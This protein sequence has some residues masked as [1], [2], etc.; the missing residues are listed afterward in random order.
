[1]AAEQADTIVG[2]QVELKGSLKNHG[3]IH[4]HGFVTGDIHSDAAVIIGETAVVTGPVSA[5]V[6]EVGG[7]VHGSITAEEHIELHPKSLVKGDLTTKRLS[8]KAG[9]TFIGKSSM[10]TPHGDNDEIEKKKPRLE[11]E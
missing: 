10:P 3:S 7:Q 1:M 9:A 2:A 8:I 6:V 4:I 11:V 5:K